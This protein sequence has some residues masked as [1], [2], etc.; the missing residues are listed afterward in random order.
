M[1][2]LS[3]EQIVGVSDSLLSEKNIS[4]YQQAHMALIL[5]SG[6]ADVFTLYPD[7]AILSL[8]DQMMRTF[9]IVGIRENNPP[10]VALAYQ[11]AD[12]FIDRYED[13]NLLDWALD[14]IKYNRT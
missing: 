1:K 9:T 11:L 3:D 10:M 5:L 13:L 12:E 8:R 14:V 4:E 2:R 6:Y 7:T